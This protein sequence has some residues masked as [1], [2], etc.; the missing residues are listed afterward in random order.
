[1]VDGPKKP[2]PHP[3]ERPSISEQTEIPAAVPMTPLVDDEDM[4]IFTPASLQRYQ[5][6]SGGGIL[7]APGDS[8]P[9]VEQ[10]QKELRT[11]G[12]LDEVTEGEGTFGADTEQAV[13]TF[14]EANGFVSTGKVDNRTRGIL[15]EAARAR[16]A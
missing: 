12:L 16:G 15:R 1:M 3:P 2:A 7:L 5:A 4:G 6:Q 8:G 9:A 13:R 10:L 11:L 14:Q